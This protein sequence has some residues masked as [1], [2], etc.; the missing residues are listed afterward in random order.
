MKSCLKCNSFYSECTFINKILKF[1]CYCFYCFWRGGVI[2][3]GAQGVLAQGCVVRCASKVISLW[4]T[5][6]T[7]WR[8]GL[9]WNCLTRE[10][11]YSLKLDTVT[12]IDDSGARGS[13][14]KQTGND[15]W[16]S[17]NPLKSVYTAPCPPLTGHTLGL[18]QDLEAGPEKMLWDGDTLLALSPLSKALV[19]FTLHS[20]PCSQGV[21]TASK[22]LET[23]QCCRAQ[24]STCYGCL[25]AAL[26]CVLFGGQLVPAALPVRK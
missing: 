25:H 5:R 19:Y 2:L 1:T 4:K 11:F 23:L 24:C 26:L 22:S 8:K 12:R 10:D 18:T 17:T 20:V 9:L 7:S 14:Q 16:N 13:F 21:G 3:L 15:Q 6:A